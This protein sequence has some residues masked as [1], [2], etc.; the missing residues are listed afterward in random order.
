VIDNY[1]NGIAYAIIGLY[2]A[3]LV[4]LGLRLKVRASAGLEQ[5][6][7]GNRSMP[8]WMLGLSGVMD[9]WDLAG[10]MIIVSFLFLL[11][12]RGLFIEFRGGAVLVLALQMLWA[13]KW[14]RRSG[15]MTAAEWMLFRFGD[16]AA[17]R[18]AQLARAIAGIVLT[19]GTI[20]YLVK[21]AGL[22][23]SVFVPYS[24]AQCAFVVVV[25]ATV[26]SMFSGFYGVVIIHILQLGVVLAAMVAVV[27]LSLG[28]TGS[29][30]ELATL[31]EQ[32]TGNAHWIE[33][34]PTLHATMPTGYEAYESLLLLAT[35][36]LL[37]NVVFGMG[38]GDDPKYFAA[39]SDADCGKFTLLWTCLMSLRWPMAL[40]LAVLGLT[41]VRQLFPDLEA[42]RQAAEAVRTHHTVG[43]WATITAEIA[44]APDVQPPVLVAQL[45]AILGD[46]WPARLQLVSEHG[47]INPERIM[48][49]VLLYAIPPGLRSLMVVSLIAAA[50]AGFGALVNQ[51]TGF[52]T[53]DI[54]QK[55]VRPTAQVRELMLATWTF[56]A[57]LVT[58]GF[59][60]AFSARNLNDVWAWII[61]GLGSGMMFPQMLP[62][63]WRRFNG[64]GYTTG[65]IAGVAA[66]LAQ[67]AFGPALPESWQFLN[68][69]R[70]LLPMIG[71]VGLAASIAGSLA[72][73]P[74]PEGALR[75]FYIR[76][77][78]FGLWGPNR[79]QLPA[80]LAERVAAEHRREIAALPLALVFQTTAFLTPMM[81]LIRNWQSLAWCA[82]IML[83]AF[84][85][86]FA[87]WLRRIEESDAIAS[88]ARSLLGD[89][90]VEPNSQVVAD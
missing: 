63:Y 72:S 9:F 61:M 86:L 3:V 24:P 71:L 90:S 2:L 78:P 42:A 8:W 43:D 56:I 12:P 14:H 57:A 7:L 46:D 16:G 21:G 77:L 80:A 34:A 65:M 82:V 85:G 62:L 87:I 59:L 69:E 32:V 29:V 26:Y 88:E 44:H 28:A 17:G 70:W 67:R 22:F 41:V 6:L 20:A 51:A 37:R 45:R 36:Y 19:L 47:T 55:H 13:G 33:A 64:V 74:T 89:A 4:V 84:A 58:A 11:G 53:H 75:T 25:S 27:W 5:Y 15:C 23:L 10:T 76:T 54:Y 31:A 52:F 49:A 40:G 38:A 1:L 39:R 68:A 48:P 83:A 35:L 50:M 73:R 79:R 66:A 30:A 18:A 81:A 60:F